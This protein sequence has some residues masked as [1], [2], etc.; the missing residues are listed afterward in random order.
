MWLKI[1]DLQKQTGGYKAF[2]PLDFPLREPLD[3]TEGTQGKHL[4]AMRL[5]GKLDGIC[6]LLPDR[7]FFLRMFVKKEAASSSQI[8]GTQATMIDAI[9]AEILGPSNQAGDVGDIVYYIKAL[10]YGIKRYETLPLSV[11]FIQE[12]HA[13]LMNGARST[14][15]PY[16]GQFRYTQNWIGGTSPS[17][18]SFVPPP[19]HEI[20][21]AFGDLEKFIHEPNDGIPPL[22]KA[23]LIH[24]QFETIHPFVDGNGRTGRLL[25]TFYLW[26]E[27]LLELPILYLSEFFKKHK[28]LYC[29]KLQ[30]YHSNPAEVEPWIAFFMEGIATTAKSAIEIAAAINLIRERDMQKIQSLGRLSPSTLEVLRKLFAQPIIDCKKMQEW[31]GMTR[32]GAQKVINRLLDLGIL[33]VQDINKNYARTYE[34]KDYL[35]LFKN[36]A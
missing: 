7:D 34:Y 28:S 21:R 4:E 16:P 8:E 36:E 12:L 2:I 35:T 10:D 23:A 33:V 18:A 15:N 17:N 22:I 27:K 13:Q 25:V 19:P 29:E 1:G 31:T 14:H 32:A 3:L 5:I 30:A 6:Q 9:E 11:R 26:Q 20:S 24:A